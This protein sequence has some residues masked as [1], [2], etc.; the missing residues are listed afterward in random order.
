[1]RGRA[2]GKTGHLQPNASN[3]TDRAR[4]PLG[5]HR[6]LG[7]PVVVY[8]NER[9]VESSAQEDASWRRAMKRAAMDEITELSSAMRGGANEYGAAAEGCVIFI[10]VSP[11]SGGVGWGSR[12][13][14]AFGGR[15]QLLGFGATPNKHKHQTLETP[16]VSR[17]GPAPT[18]V[19]ALPA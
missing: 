7:H 13:G 5:V 4:T 11:S 8:V 3:V 6:W 2:R 9:G 15:T 12:A 10:L 1:M 14:W 18:E 19:S 16:K 17:Q